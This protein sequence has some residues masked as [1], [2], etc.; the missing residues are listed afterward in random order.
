LSDRHICL[1]DRGAKKPQATFRLSHV[2]S[3]ERRSDQ[4]DF[5]DDALARKSVHF[6]LMYRLPKGTD[7]SGLVEV[8]TFQE[9]SKLLFHGTLG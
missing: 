7:P 8:F 4:P 5:L 6:V 3:V 2:E 9:V 1:L